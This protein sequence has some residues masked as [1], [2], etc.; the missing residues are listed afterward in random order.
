MQNLLN[1]VLTLGVPV[2]GLLIA[3]RVWTYAA[4]SGNKSPGK[5]ISGMVTVLI[6]FAAGM[7]IIPKALNWGSNMFMS[8][9]MANPGVQAG[10][11]LMGTGAGLI[12]QTLSVPSGAAPQIQV[13]Q[14]QLPQ[15]QSFVMPQQPA[16]ANQGL[17]DY[18]NQAL[19][20]SNPVSSGRQAVL[21]SQPAEPQVDVQAIQAQAVATGQAIMEQVAASNAGMV[22]AQVVMTGPYA[23]PNVAFVPAGTV[24]E[25][26]VGPYADPNQAVQ[27]Q[28]VGQQQAWQPPEVPL[29]LA[30][31]NT[32]A[33][34]PLVVAQ[35][36][37][38]PYIA[39]P[40]VTPASEV[41]VGP[42]ADPNQ[43]VVSTQ[44]EPLIAGQNMAVQEQFVG[45][46]ANAQEAVKKVLVQ[47][48]DGA[49]VWVNK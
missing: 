37:P 4:A 6:I 3:Y 24:V 47:Q 1:I 23:D 9:I 46:Y 10:I 32:P 45:P 39:P 5:V 21:P 43:A 22:P 44:Q 35:P 30:P 19:T 27:S 13:P 49:L 42:Y 15:P 8:Q 31:A 17:Q 36:T 25:K 48:A 34:A 41:F 16:A 38:T 2:I 20:G 29:V 7:V 12:D 33:P 11:G 18:I 28:V 40:T 26:F 14:I